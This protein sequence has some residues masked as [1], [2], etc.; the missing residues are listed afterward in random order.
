MFN[1]T[2][3][4]DNF[5]DK[6]KI[7]KVV[8]LQQT[9]ATSS[10]SPNTLL[11]PQDSGY[12]LLCLAHFSLLRLNRDLR[13]LLHLMSKKSQSLLYNPTLLLLMM[14]PHIQH[15]QRPLPLARLL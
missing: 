14:L 1:D 9:I 11:K 15:L 8:R 12:A 7:S 5:G 13:R 6:G 10:A 2:D 3:E 4:D